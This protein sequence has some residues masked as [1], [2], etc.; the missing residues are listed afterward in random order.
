MPSPS[1]RNR[2]KLVLS[3][4]TPKWQSRYIHPTVLRRQALAAMSGWS[5]R[6]GPFSVSNVMEFNNLCQVAST[7]ALE[8]LLL[9]DPSLCII[10]RLNRHQILS[11]LWR[12]ELTKDKI[13]DSY[14]I[15]TTAGIANTE[16]DHCMVKAL[17]LYSP[18]GESPLAQ[19]TGN[20][21]TYVVAICLSASIIVETHPRWSGEVI[22]DF[23]RGASR[24]RNWSIDRMIGEQ[25]EQLIWN[26]L[27]TL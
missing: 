25:L 27:I 3:L 8:D 21:L 2:L 26:C 5:T 12:C 14:A 23:R 24:L 22:Q 18:S 17:N 9:V 10:F 7:Q 15:L 1:T 13:V 6:S 4:E 19:L 11:T 20:E 16:F